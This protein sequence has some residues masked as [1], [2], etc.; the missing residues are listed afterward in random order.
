MKDFFKMQYYD[1]EKKGFKDGIQDLKDSNKN[2]IMN[3]KSFLVVAGVFLLIAFLKEHLIG[4]FVQTGQNFSTENSLMLQGEP[5]LG[6]VFSIIGFF[7]SLWVYFFTIDM[8]SDLKNASAKDSSKF[9]FFKLFDYRVYML[10]FSFLLFCLLSFRIAIYPFF[11]LLPEG[12]STVTII[13]YFQGIMAVSANGVNLDS[14]LMTFINS[15]QEYLSITEAFNQMLNNPISL[16][17]CFGSAV[18]LFI[19]TTVFHFSMFVNM[20]VFN[21]MTFFEALKASCKLNIKNGLYVFSSTLGII[22][23]L[24]VIMLLNFFLSLYSNYIIEII[25]NNVLALYSIYIFT[26]LISNIT[27]E[28]K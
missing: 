22:A 9:A 1:I 26:Y 6:F 15:K 5:N 21:G 12:I 3:L 14:S 7:I 16:F 20:I 18:L 17:V 11:T 8:F 10:A 4:T 25:L 19:V 28:K 27:K 23:I 2:I 24:S 13:E